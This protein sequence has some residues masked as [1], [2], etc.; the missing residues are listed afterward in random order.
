MPSVRF[1]GQAEPNHQPAKKTLGTR[2]RAELERP[3]LAQPAE[4]VA[5]VCRLVANAS[6]ELAAIKA[7]RR[8]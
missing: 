6:T 5:T 8:T 1:S 4:V 2:W 3:A 7:D